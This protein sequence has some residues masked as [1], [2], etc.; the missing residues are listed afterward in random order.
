MK[1]TETQLA[2]TLVDQLDGA[3]EKTVKAVAQDIVQALAERREPHR[4]RGLIDALERASFGSA[5]VLRDR[6]LYNLGLAQ[7]RRAGRAEGQERTQSVRGALS[8]YRTLLLAHPD[9]ADARWNYELALRLR[10]APPPSS[11]G[12]SRDEQQAPPQQQRDP[13]T[14]SQQQAEQLL[15]AASRDERDTQSR[16]RRVPQR[17]RAPGG[18]DW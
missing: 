7:L 11:G 9:D 1:K 13:S 8:A 15:D 18:K 6:A 4:V 14:M 5:P 3:D 10:Q 16:R 12:G 17:D 2:C